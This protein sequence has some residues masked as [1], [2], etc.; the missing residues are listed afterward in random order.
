MAGSDPKKS[1]MISNRMLLKTV[2]FFTELPDTDIDWFL[3]QARFAEYQKNNL[4]FQHGDPAESLYVV[5]EGWIKLFHNSAE[6]EQT[7]HALLTRGDMFGEECVAKGRSYPCSAQ[8]MGKSA[9]CL[10][11]PA[12]TMRERLISHPDTALYMLSSLADQ[13]N[14]TGFLLE[15][16]SQLTAAQR[17]SAFLLK[18]CLDRG[19]VQKVMLPFNKFLV[20]ERLGMKPETFSRALRRLEQ[21]INISFKG[22]EVSIGDIQA[23]QDYCEVYCA[24]DNAC[25]HE[26]SL[27]EKLL[28]SKAECDIC[29]VL[30]LM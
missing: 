24:R 25:D 5:I 29:R 1:N 15:I 3:K 12:H 27:K 26:C 13:L 11:I 17:V 9:R 4:L 14:K 28:C 21:D 30:K 7:V 16:S 10:I 2:P 6:G 20:A 22:R 19:G 8:I 18:L 23:L